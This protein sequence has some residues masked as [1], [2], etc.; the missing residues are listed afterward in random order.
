MS[1]L[2]F[3]EEETIVTTPMPPEGFF[4]LR[5]QGKPDVLAFSHAAFGLS[6]P[7]KDTFKCGGL[8]F[9]RDTNEPLKVWVRPS[10]HQPVTVLG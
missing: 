10:P 4:K 3:A 9:T 1:L 8:T 5:M 2:A 7:V 6:W